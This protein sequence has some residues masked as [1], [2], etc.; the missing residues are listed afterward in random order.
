MALEKDMSITQIETFLLKGDMQDV[1][2]Y[3]IEPILH[4]KKEPGGYFGATREILCMVDFLG[5]MYIGKSRA[6]SKGAIK[7]IKEV[8]RSGSSDRN[9]EKNGEV[10][11]RMYRHGLVHL[12]QPKK[13]I[14]D[15]I[16]IEWGVYKGERKEKSLEIKS[17]K[18]TYIYKNV[19]HLEIKKHQ[20]KKDTYILFISLKCL[21]SDFRKSLNEYFKLIKQKDKKYLNRWRKVANKITDYELY[22]ADAKNF[23]K[24]MKIWFEKVVKNEFY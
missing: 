9:Y 17:S 5:A 12:F 1:I 18:K 3:D 22:D 24:S 6:Y 20:D 21:F 14:K 2:R 11:Y 23:L 15:K 16:E 8:I 10:M 13:Y 7:F 4:L 19:R